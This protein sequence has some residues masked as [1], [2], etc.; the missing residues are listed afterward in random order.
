MTPMRLRSEAEHESDSK[1]GSL[2]SKGPLKKSPTKSIHS[3][4]H[5]PLKSVWKYLLLGL[6][7]HCIYI[8]S[9][10]DIYFKSPL[11][12]GL[13]PVKPTRPAPAKRLVMFIGDGLRADKAFENDEKGQARMPFLRDEIAKQ[14]GVWGISHT[15]VP[16][17]S[18]PGH[19]A[20]LAGFYEDVSAVTKGWKKNPVEFDHIPG[21]AKRAWTFGAPD[22]VKLFPE[23]RV[24]Q[25]YYGEEMVDFGRDA[26][27]QDRWVFDKLKEVFEEAEKD[28]ELGEQL[29][30][31]Q[32][33]I[34][35]HLLG[36]DT[37][38][39]AYRPHSP[40]YHA[41]VAYVDKG[42][43]EAV[44]MM[45]RFFGD[46]K[47]AYVFTSDHGMSDGGT[48]GD[49]DPANTRCPLIVWGSGVG[50]PKE[51]SVRPNKEEAE[52][53]KGWTMEGIQRRDI[54]QAD[55][56]PLMA[57]LIGIAIPTNSVGELPVEYIEATEEF[58]LR[59]S[60][61][62]LKQLLT[63]YSAK[64]ER[65]ISQEVLFKR[66]FK[67]NGSQLSQMTSEIEG[68]IDKGEYDGAHAKIK[69]V[70][71]LLHDGLR[72][73]QKYDWLLLRIVISLGYVGWIVYSL[74][75]LTRKLNGS[76]TV[77]TSS[78]M[79]L[80]ICMSIGCLSV[81]YLMAKKAP[82]QYYAYFGF[83]IYFA[84]LVVS[85]SKGL[86]GDRSMLRMIPLI[87]LYVLGLEVAVICF[88][89]RSVLA[90]VTPLLATTML[91]I[92]ENGSFFSSAIMWITSSL[93]GV[94]CL[95]EPIKEPNTLV[96][97]SGGLVISAFVLTINRSFFNFGGI[98]ASVA[99]AYQADQAFSAKIQASPIL[100]FG[101]WLI[102]LASLVYPI[103][104]RKSRASTSS[105]ARLLDIFAIT[106][107]GYIMLSV[108]YYSSSYFI[109][110]VNTV[111]CRY[112]PLFYVL[113]AGPLVYLTHLLQMSKHPSN[114]ETKL[115]R[116]LLFSYKLLA[117]ILL[118][119]F[120]TGNFASIA[121]FSLPSVYRLITV[122]SPFTMS[123]LLIYKLLIPLI[124]LS[125]AF[126]AILR[127]AKLSPMAVFL[128][129]IATI[130]IVTLNFF[131]LVRDSGSWLEIG[132]SISH[133]I[134]ASVFSLIALLIFS[135]SELLITFVDY[136]HQGIDLKRKE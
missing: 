1:I 58:K 126:A 116:T 111:I 122:F 119:F 72:Y 133:F 18:R 123:A 6:V 79:T 15:R 4:V 23:E 45:E 5:L 105:A 31:E 28:E 78:R 59:A 43:K 29:R 12:T 87:L 75:Y 107:A 98:V 136:S 51:S 110:P 104:T 69:K 7:F 2:A 95:L 46:G 9:I 109:F 37:N 10:F 77:L 53:M 93:V 71:T 89:N 84:Y 115:I 19:V 48:H 39:H 125:A 131:F 102:V 134:I 34:L 118:A 100:H 36:L 73:Y 50:K 22:I 21:R 94:F 52:L 124:F 101:G 117:Y 113:Y 129:L 17:E 82:I 40:E 14:H 103:A 49:G 41:N 24:R 81:M 86:V 55:L 30:D 65:C 61:V 33:F 26:I 38:G 76:N 96:W 83:P 67:V 56:T 120:G 114:G 54:N 112:E 57:S 68:L 108:S 128:A 8:L 20:M 62:N 85:Q 121:S 44:I 130:D 80:L 106:S 63:T 88:F 74:I 91:S 13:P 66:T 3:F 60:V 42:I 64:E 90:F 97:I 11:V 27:E 16:T 99:I 92:T 35:V 25:Y 70:Y 135:L 127:A 32:V 47:T 132:T